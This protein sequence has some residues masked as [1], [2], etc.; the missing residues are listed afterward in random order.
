MNIKKAT[1]WLLILLCTAACQQTDSD[2]ALYKRD[3][4][5]EPRLTT[6]QL[7]NNLYDTNSAGLRKVE[8]GY[9]AERVREQDLLNRGGV[10][11]PSINKRHLAGAISELATSIDDVSDTTTLATDKEVLIA[12]QGN[13]D[14]RE[15]LAD[16]VKKSALS[17]IPRWYHVYVADDADLQSELERLGEL[18]AEAE[19]TR[20]EVDQ[21]IEHMIANYPQGEKVSTVENENGERNGQSKWYKDSAPQDAK[22]RMG[23]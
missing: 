6:E 2:Q 14:D 17:L 16:Q 20:T 9:A 13:G 12:Y 1:P 8:N 5:D 21:M 3:T 7:P 23:Q 15:E 4:H 22:K 11:S 19:A 18:P 10:A